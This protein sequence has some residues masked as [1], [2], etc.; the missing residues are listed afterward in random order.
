MRQLP[1]LGNQEC[2]IPLAID[3]NHP[4]VR[5]TQEIDWQLLEEI[6]KERRQL[7]VKSSRGQQPNY[8][9]NCGAVVVRSL[10]SLDLRSTEDMIRNYL[11]A[12]Y[13]C[14]LHNSHYTPDHDTI[15]EFETMLGEEGLAQFSEHILKMAEGYGFA[16]TKGLCADTTAQEAKIPYPN[17][18]GLMGAFGKSLSRSLSTLG[19]VVGG[20]KNKITGKLKDL[21]QNLR[22]HRLFSKTKES[23]LKVAAKM[24][25]I[26]KDLLQDVGQLI[27]SVSKNVAGSKRRAANH[28]AEVY[29]SMMQLIGQIDHWI[30]TGWPAPEKIISLF[31]IDLRSIPWGKIGKDVEFGLKW[32]I[33]QIRGGYIRLFMMN[34]MRSADYNYAVEAIREHIRIFGVAPDEYG[35][36]RGGWSE[37]HMEEM[38]E[39][40]VRRVGVAPKGKEAWKVSKSCEERIK[41]ERAQ[42]EG[43]IG[44]IKHYGFNKPEERTTPGMKRAARRA[45][46]R[47][48]LTRLFRDLT[49]MT[50]LQA[51]AA[52]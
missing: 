1:L 25:Q 46:L 22:K 43:K 49:G 21:A 52:A 30:K 3:P 19:A 7:V 17:E 6:S 18:V 39:L 51:M 37:S 20:L 10:K 9:A 2:V 38:R 27:G 31:Q 36:D 15:W 48:N 12:R 50:V 41:L 45:E 34:E 16:D 24:S 4:L 5:L 8:R 44:T 29:N 32:G 23:R 40:G 26:T 28:M 35:F 42:V 13:M 11:P 33:N 14:D 47:F